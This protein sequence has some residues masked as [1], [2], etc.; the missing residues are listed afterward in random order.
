MGY[1][2]YDIAHA[3]AHD[4]DSCHGY[5]SQSMS[6]HDGCLRSYST[7]IGQRIERPGQTPLWLVQNESYSSSTSKHQNYMRN[8]MDNG[9]IVDVS[10]YG[11]K[12]GW[13]GIYT[14][15]YM[16]ESLFDLC[17]GFITDFYELLK[18]IPDSTSIKSEDIA[19]PAPEINT[20][21]EATG[22]ITWKKLA[23]RNWG[24][25]TN[26]TRAIQ[27][28][29]LTIALEHGNMSIP[30]LVV[31]VFGSKAWAKHI[32]LTLPQQKARETRRS[33]EI[34]G[35]KPID[36]NSI[37]A[38]DF[39][40]EVKATRERQRREENK[41]IAH[42]L[43]RK[44][45]WLIGEAYSIDTYAFSERARKKIFDGGNVALRI[46]GGVVQTSKGI[47]I[48][49]EECARLWALIQ[50]WHNNHAEF[51]RDICHATTNRWTISSFEND[52]MTAGC[53]SI[54]YSE[55]ARIAK[56]LKLA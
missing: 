44:E 28:R 19:S 4:L 34:P 26:R 27:L 24:A 5:C 40:A 7:V 35:Y 42:A 43:K 6:H 55:M 47:S 36:F 49:F 41:H 48:S 9:P 22:C 8:A 32:A 21:I 51:H 39:E 37:E 52:I 45:E 10:K 56:E 53:H 20:L 25:N 3:W 23:S 1:S 13:S 16:N 14:G 30:Q 15:S 33:K 18:L 54:A 38:Y 11:F 2:H 17:V 31:A 12:F 29:K 50:R 46:H